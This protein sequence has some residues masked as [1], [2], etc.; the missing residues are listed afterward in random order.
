MYEY[1]A[2]GRPILA[3]V[4][5]SDARDFLTQIGTA[6][7]CRPDDADGMLKILKMAFD[8]WKARKS[9]PSANA[10]LLRRFE[11][12]T[13]THALAAQFDDALRAPGR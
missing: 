6:L 13:L 9:P 2:S 3:A 12:R 1:M 11:R 7:V 8:S 4:P 10:E 5:D